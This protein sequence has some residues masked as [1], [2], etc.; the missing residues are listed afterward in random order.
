MTTAQAGSVLNQGT[1]NNLTV[2]GDF[3]LEPATFVKD[4]GNGT[5]TFDGQ[6][7]LDVHDQNL[8]K[9]RF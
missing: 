5:V 3:T 7:S 9:V 4:A 8:G 6:F 2:T 1:N